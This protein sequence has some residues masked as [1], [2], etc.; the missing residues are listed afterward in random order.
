[1]FNA[2]MTEQWKMLPV[3]TILLELFV[4]LTVFVIAERNVAHSSTNFC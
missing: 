4:T 1:M 2:F 3:L